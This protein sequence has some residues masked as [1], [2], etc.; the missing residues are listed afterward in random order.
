[1]T[2]TRTV[3]FLSVGGSPAPLISAIKQS[4]PDEVVFVVSDAR[5]G[6]SSEDM[7]PEILQGSGR[8][9]RHG[10]IRVDPDN[11]DDAFAK[12]DAALAQSLAGG[13]QVVVDYTG[14][15]KTMTA[16]M[17]LAATGHKDVR[18]Q[19]MVGKRNDLQRI[20]DGSEQ[21]QEMPRALLGVAQIF[22]SA[23]DFVSHRNYGAALRVLEKLKRDLSG[24][25]KGAP[26]PPKTWR[27]RLD[28]DIKA[29]AILDA[30]D[31][32][33]HRTA[34]ANLENAY[35]SGSPYAEAMVSG[36]MLERL[37]PLAAG[38]PTPELLEDL[39]LNAQRRA[40]LGLYDDALARL[41]RLAEATVQTYLA[42]EG[43]DT[44]SVPFDR[45]S[46]RLREK[47]Q[48]D[49]CATAKLSLSDARA[50]L[51]WLVPDCA[52]FKAWPDGLP[53]WQGTRNNS[54]LA[55]GFKPISGEGYH[56]AQRWFQQRLLPCWRELLG[57][58]L[59]DQLPGTLPR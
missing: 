16:A 59:L 19:F 7:L 41:Y 1:M 38:G 43:I 26:R 27:S 18:L 51:L 39:W 32:F 3:L 56:V 31:R 22:R 21:A 15:T 2:D 14:G 9:A 44:A 49:R 30:W 53:D 25:P 35:A 24:N 23:D 47:L 34:R 36:G 46:P 29:L 11:L 48:K 33:D 20:E 8:N 37:K 42:R 55:H 50:Q 10:I 45:L 54:I 5:N 6:L 17:T 28:S 58:P 13:A 40:A 4:R 57:R 52:L 12:V